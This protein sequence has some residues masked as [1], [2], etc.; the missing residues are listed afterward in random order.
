MCWK[1]MQHALDKPNTIVITDRIAKKYFG[2]VSAVG[3]TMICDNE[4]R[5]VTAVIG[6]RPAN[7]DHQNRSCI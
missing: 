1:V 2:N 3:K 4:N 7:S 6:D 5:M